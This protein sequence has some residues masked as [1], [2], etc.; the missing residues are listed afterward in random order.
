MILTI[1]FTYAATA[2]ESFSQLLN[3]VQSIQANFSQKT[4]DVRGRVSQKASGQMALQRPGKFRWEIKKPMPQLIIANQKKLWIYDPDLEQ[5]TIRSL[6][7]SSDETPA[8]LLSHDNSAL[9]THFTIT[10]MDKN[11]SGWQWFMLKPKK[12]DNM[13]ASIQMGFTNKHIQEMRL[14]DN[15]GN[16]TI[17]DFSNIKTNLSLA[18]ASFQFKPRANVDVIDETRKK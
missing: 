3:G 14:Q 17:I 7:E 13:F 9:D 1:S 5:V 12:P 15:L 6:N 8:L 18:A 2:T 10:T 16:V 11:Q 4:V